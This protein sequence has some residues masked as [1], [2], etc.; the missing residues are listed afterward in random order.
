MNLVQWAIRW[1]V[2]LAALQ[3][4]E[5]E[6]G[7]QGGPMPANAQGKSEAWA[8]SAVMLEAPRKGVRLWR[9]NVGALKDESGRM[10]RYGLANRSAQENA[11]LKSGDL[12]GIRKQRITQEMVG[13]FTGQFVSREIKEPG[14]VFN[15]ADEHEAAQMAWALMI[16]AMGG[17]AGFATGEGTL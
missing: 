15:P 4:L 14:W 5:Q 13:S 11:L 12:I 16:C 7:A 9:N 10:V 3:E 17:D 2:P 6:I 8:Q 1:G